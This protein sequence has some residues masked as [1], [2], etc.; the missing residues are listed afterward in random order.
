[1]YAIRSYYV[2]LDAER[3]DKEW[4]YIPALVLLGVVVMLQRARRTP[5]QPAA[6]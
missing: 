2:E 4:F 3:M 6:A 5:A 1:M